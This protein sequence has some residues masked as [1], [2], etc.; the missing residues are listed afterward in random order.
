MKF[1]P[2]KNLQTT[3][4]LVGILSVL[5]LLAGMAL[6]AAADHHEVC[7]GFSKD[8][9]IRRLGT[10]G[11]IA[12]GGAPTWE[13][14]A[15]KVEQHRSDLEGILEAQG[16]GNLAPALFE[17][18]STGKVTER[19]LANGETFQWMALRKRGAATSK[20]PV[21]LN[22]RK[23]YGAF[24]VTVKVVKEVKV[25]K[26]S[27]GFKAMADCRNRTLS[28]ALNADSSG[29]TV[30]MDGKEVVGAGSTSWESAF[31][32]RFDNSPTFI[33]RAE[34]RGSKTVE[35]YTF[36]IPK[37]CLNLALANTTTT[38]EV[39][40]VQKCEEKA[41]VGACPK[42][43]CE[44]TPPVG[45]RKRKPFTATIEGEGTVKIDRVVDEKRG[46]EWPYADG[47]KVK[48]KGYYTL[49]G[50]SETEF[51]D[52]E[53]CSARFCVGRNCP[54]TL[55]PAVAAAST[56]RT[57]RDSA[58]T[59]RGFA[60]PLSGD[61]ELRTVGLRADGTSE[62]TKLQAGDGFLAG[63][64]AEYHFNDRVGL[65]GAIMTGSLDSM[66]TLDLNN[67]WGM[68]SDDLG[69]FALTLGPNFH[70]TPNSRM[71]FYV[72]PFVGLFN[73]SEGEYRVLGESVKK[74]FDNE[75]VF[76]AQAGLGIPFGDS[77]W[78]LNLGLRYFA[79][80]LEEDGG[81]TQELDLDPIAAT[82]GFAYRF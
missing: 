5:V 46:T 9:T 24:E 64:G 74:D 77:P 82:V 10:S 34:N 63:V 50:T 47:M 71:D 13:H 25:D 45:P 1:L 22:S 65:E 33:A 29:A 78:G 66:F 28:V 16:L 48:K 7:D 79:L 80:S 52:T 62:R 8:N 37:A 51:G 68:E 19:T 15:R 55:P 11:A 35:T 2:F 60:G 12:K 69:F 67:D 54:E 21:C 44:I 31:E 53:T 18:I 30:E 61:D 17:A 76:G 23:S 41:T 26:P 75:V 39:G 73:V 70:L 57:P 42:P 38:Q 40:D 59:L 27:C 58:W 4:A 32:N 49:Y 72:G 20:G 56:S 36:V 43:Y 6:P 14:L 3:P 81:A